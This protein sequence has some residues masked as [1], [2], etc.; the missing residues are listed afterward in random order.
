MNDIIFFIVFGL[1][2]GFCTLSAIILATNEE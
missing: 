1:A 2:F